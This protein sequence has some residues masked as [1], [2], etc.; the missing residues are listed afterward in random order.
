[1]LGRGRGGALPAEQGTRGVLQ[2]PRL[3]RRRN[4]RQEDVRPRLHEQ[5]QLS[6]RSTARSVWTRATATVHVPW[7]GPPQGDVADVR[8][9]Y[10]HRSKKLAISQEQDKPINLLWVDK[11]LAKRVHP[12]G[13]PDERLRRLKKVEIAELREQL[14]RLG[15]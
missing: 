15:G 8:E 10:A 6:V 4:V 5:R 14:G 11:N 12:D 7:R 3:E 13:Q 2:P 9:L 1:M